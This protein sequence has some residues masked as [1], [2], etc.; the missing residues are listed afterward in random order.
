MHAESVLEFESLRTVISRYVRSALGRAELD[1]LA[2]VA[3]RAAIESALA[4][5][6]E[7]IEYLRATSQPQAASSGA[8][9][10]I[11]VHP[12]RACASKA[13]LWRRQEFSRSPGCLTWRPRRGRSWWPLANDFRGSRGTRLGSPI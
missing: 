1:A 8:A 7:G 10:P 11:R 3:D 9:M 4:D 2:P 5:A 6:A 13:R 12:S